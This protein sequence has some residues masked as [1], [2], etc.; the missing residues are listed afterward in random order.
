MKQ[1]QEDEPT[2]AEDFLR[3]W[4]LEMIKSLKLPIKSTEQEIR[5][6]VLLRHKTELSALSELMI[7]YDTFYQ[8]SIC[9]SLKFLSEQLSLIYAQ[10][11]D[12]PFSQ[13]HK[14]ALSQFMNELWNMEQTARTKMRDFES[15]WFAED[16]VRAFSYVAQYAFAQNHYF[17]TSFPLTIEELR[18]QRNPQ[19]DGSD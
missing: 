2:T 18:N 1:E 10:P 13:L 19:S 16:L 9:H 17:G 5:R 4:E 14:A 11:I 15:S 3:A 6:T 12:Q 7:P 8:T